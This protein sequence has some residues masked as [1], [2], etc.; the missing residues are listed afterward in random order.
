MA[1]HSS[2]LALKISW[3]EKPGRMHG[4]AKTWTRLKRLT[5]H[6]LVQVRVILSLSVVIFSKGSK[7][8]WT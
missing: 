3:A 5:T 4:V 7:I 8:V 2:I 1:T 6:C